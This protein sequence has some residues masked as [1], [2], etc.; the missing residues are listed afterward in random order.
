MNISILFLDCSI[1]ESWFT[2]LGRFS[3]TRNEKLSR[4]KQDS[5][6]E[7]CLDRKNYCS[8]WENLFGIELESIQPAPNW[9][10]MRA[11][12]ASVHR[13]S[14]STFSSRA[15]PSLERDREGERQIKF[16]RIQ[17]AR[18]RFWNQ[19]ESLVARNGESSVQ[20]V[21]L[22]RIASRDATECQSADWRSTVRLRKCRKLV[23]RAECKSTS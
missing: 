14:S 3:L 17:G 7:W 21:Y 6:G 20:F 1:E 9:I 12:L 19:I 15:C 18:L 22:F 4:S 13:E 23:D 5:L 10:E 8:T 16:W 2:L 11:K